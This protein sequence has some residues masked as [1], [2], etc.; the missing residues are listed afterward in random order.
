[1]SYEQLHELWVNLNSYSKT[2]DKDGNLQ[3]GKP[4]CRIVEK[5]DID[6]ATAESDP[7]KEEEGY[8]V[9]VNR[10]GLPPIKAKIKLSEYKRLHRILTGLTPQMIWE[11][12]ALPMTPWLA[13][14]CKYNRKTGETTHSMPVPAEF[15]AWVKQWQRGLTKAFHENLVEAVKAVDLLHRFE[16][17]TGFNE[18]YGGF[19]NDAARK[20]WFTT[21]G[22]KRDIVDVAMLLYKGHEVDAYESLWKLVRPHGKDDRFYV[23]GKGE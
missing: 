2:L 3:P 13:V 10:Q 7:S 4:W 11:E 19:K 14:D 21:Q 9:S 22:F 17:G 6:I 5:F 8:V 16:E 1:M 23:E 12:L 20:E 15:A 18:V